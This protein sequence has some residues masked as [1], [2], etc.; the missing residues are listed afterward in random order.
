MTNVDREQLREMAKTWLAAYESDRHSPYDDFQT[1]VAINGFAAGFSRAFDFPADINAAAEEWAIRLVGD[2]GKRD[3]AAW[4]M[5]I[6]AFKAGAA[7]AWALAGRQDT[8]K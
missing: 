3:S 6:A 5:L 7:H 4:A 8:G 2:R 1:A